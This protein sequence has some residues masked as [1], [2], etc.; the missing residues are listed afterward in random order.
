MKQLKTIKKLPPIEEIIN[1]FPVS[2]AAMA[3]VAR[4]QQE[5]KDILAGKDARTLFIV[6]PCS[7]WPSPAVLEYA[8]RLKALEPQVADVLKLVLRVY[9]QKP[10]TT[11]GWT[12]PV[13]QPD[14]F[15]A[16]DIAEGAYYTRKMM[17][18]VAEMGLP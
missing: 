18:E 11:I 16:P 6:G 9:I 2:D 8:K 5:V 10:R 15:A 12:G 1:A 4:N 3:T 14:P 13:N 17:A 7:A